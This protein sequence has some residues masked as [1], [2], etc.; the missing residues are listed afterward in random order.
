MS[1]HI[2]SNYGGPGEAIITGITLSYSSLPVL[3]DFL[4]DTPPAGLKVRIFE[5]TRQVFIQFTQPLIMEFK[6]PWLCEALNSLIQ[7][8][9]LTALPTFY[10]ANPDY[11]IDLQFIASR[12]KSSYIRRLTRNMSIASYMNSNQ[13]A[14]REINSTYPNGRTVNAIKMV[15]LEYDDK[16][17]ERIRSVQNSTIFTIHNVENDIYLALSPNLNSA[18][19]IASNCAGSET[20]LISQEIE[21]ICATIGV[22]PPLAISVQRVFRHDVSDWHITIT[23]YEAPVAPL[24]PP[25]VCRDAKFCTAR[26]GEFDAITILSSNRSEKIDMVK[27]NASLKYW[28]ITTMSGG[29]HVLLPRD[30]TDE[31]IIAEMWKGP[32]SI[33]EREIAKIAG[34]FKITCDTITVNH[35]HTPNLVVEGLGGT[36][37]I[38]SI[39]EKLKAGEAGEA[40]DAVEAVEAE[41]AVE[42]V[43]A[44]ES[45]EITPICDSPGSF[46]DSAANFLKRL[47]ATTQH[48]RASGDNVKYKISIYGRT[49][50]RFYEDCFIR[51]GKNPDFATIKIISSRGPMK[52]WEFICVGEFIGIRPQRFDTF[53]ALKNLLCGEFSIAEREFHDVCVIFNYCKYQIIDVVFS[54]PGNPG[55]RSHKEFNRVDIAIKIEEERAKMCAST[56]V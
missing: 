40:E 52:F 39:A 34:I 41:D 9:L 33:A 8:G 49:V 36:F 28:K 15:S 35:S 44:V 6:S 23:S 4:S 5:A 7:G 12:D 27:L 26:M 56:T 54:V 25:V 29:R 43:E 48:P 24:A 2:Y 32:I 16:S 13:F 38:E 53:A 46:A 37:S 30:F 20:T 42:A 55:S 21:F 1:S 19:G 14:L 10:V 18:F 3:E 22:H 47:R 17:I 11:D 50:P 31:K 45:P 51:M